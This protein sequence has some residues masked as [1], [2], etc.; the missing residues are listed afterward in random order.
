M[1]LGFVAAPLLCRADMTRFDCNHQELSADGTE[2]TQQNCN[3]WAQWPEI[4]KSTQPVFVGRFAV[5]DNQAHMRVMPDGSL[6]PYDLPGI[7][8]VLQKYESAERKKN[9]V[10][11]AD[12][13][14]LSKIKASRDAEMRKKNGRVKWSRK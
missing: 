11:A 2:F 8:A 4:V 1:V 13:V 7:A 10:N 9:T 6:N 14:A 12:P 3:V 5:T